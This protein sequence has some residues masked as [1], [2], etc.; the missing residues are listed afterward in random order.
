MADPSTILGFASSM[1]GIIDLAM[2]IQTA[3]YDAAL[4]N[5]MAKRHPDFVINDLP[6]LIAFLQDIKNSFLNSKEPLPAAAEASMR[7]CESY[8]IQLKE[9]LHKLY[10]PGLD[11]KLTVSRRLRI[12]SRQ[13]TLGNGYRSFRQSVLLLKDVC[14]F[15]KIQ[16]LSIKQV[17]ANEVNE[18]SMHEVLY[19]KSML[20]ETQR[21]LYDQY[22]HGDRPD[23]HHMQKTSHR[24][25][26]MVRHTH[27]YQSES[28]YQ[29]D[30]NDASLLRLQ[31]DLQL[32]YPDKT[33]LTAVICP[34]VQGDQPPKMK[35]ARVLLD[36]G[37]EVNVVSEK[38]LQEVGLSHLIT[39]IPE[40]EQFDMGGIEEQGPAWRFKRKFTSRF[41]LYSSTTTDTAEFFVTKSSNWDILISQKQYVK[42]VAERS[43]A[44]K[45]FLWMPKRKRDPAKEAEQR[46]FERS[47][48]EVLENHS[49]LYEE[50]ENMKRSSQLESRY[51]P[52]AG[53]AWTVDDNR[54][55]IMP[56]SISEASGSGMGDL[57][58]Q[59]DS[60]DDQ[61]LAKLR[62]ASIKSGTMQDEPD[63]ESKDIN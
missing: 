57:S 36:T 5:R 3:L 39:E 38:Y 25:Q 46:E 45:N 28:E 29:D 2:K 43:S 7:S 62:E 37:S 21:I 42:L 54:R 33:T 9:E 24:S 56:A 16:E 19:L 41:Y 6:V 52:A 50:R 15:F 12:S 61:R 30:I 13:K 23:K 55:A 44:S 48:Q 1:I 14:L 10:G 60:I 27:Q 20:F 8:M 59:M 53:R 18:R 58:I 26:S 22:G 49:R 11:G 32:K 4:L 35:V 17:N 47:R 63:D 51:L 31:L 40:D 34:E